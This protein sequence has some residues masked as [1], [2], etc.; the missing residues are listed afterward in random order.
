MTS[1]VAF[2][3]QS[4][5]FYLFFIFFVTEYCYVVPAGLDHPPASASQVLDCRQVLGKHLA[6]A[7]SLDWVVRETD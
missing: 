3:I 6:S 7:F 2:T 1:S 5:P 4:A